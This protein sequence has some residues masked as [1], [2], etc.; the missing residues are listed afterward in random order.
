MSLLRYNFPFL[1][2]YCLSRF[3]HCHFLSNCYIIQYQYCF[4]LSQYYLFLISNCFFLQHNFYFPEF[5]YHIQQHDYF[6]LVRYYG[7]Q[8]LHYC[9]HKLRFWS[10]YLNCNCLQQYFSHLS[11]D[12]FCLR[13]NWFP[14]F[15]QME[16]SDSHMYL[17]IEHNQLI[18]GHKQ[19]EKQWY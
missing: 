11:Q 17:D 10:Q 2:Q 15:L 18:P 12:Y 14:Q 3:L 1:W 5:H 13:Y 16:S 8:L 9:S 19:Q 7:N 4:F 6:I